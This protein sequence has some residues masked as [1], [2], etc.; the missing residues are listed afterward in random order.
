M[1]IK[2]SV[3]IP[4]RNRASLL[5]AT[6]ESI[7][8]QTYDQ[9]LFEVIVCDN[10]S[11]D[12]IAEIAHYFTDKFQHFRY[13]K[14]LE[15][16]LH[17]GRNK[18]FQEAKGEIL[19]YIDDD[20]E[21]FP[22]WLETIND[23]FKEKDVVLVGGKNLPKWEIAPP[24]WA[25]EMWKPNND[26]DRMTGSFSIIDL[27]NQIKEINPYY[28]F[29]CNFSIRKNIIAETQG[30]HPDGMPQEII[31]YRGD[32]ESYVSGYIK[33]RGYKTIYHPQASVYH[34]VTKERLTIEY[35]WKRGFNQGV[36]DS[37]T[38]IRNPKIPSHK[39]VINLKL[40]LKGVL[41]SMFKFFKNKPPETII[42]V[43]IYY[44]AMDEGHKE[45][46]CFHQQKVEE[47]PELKAW[48]M[49]DNYLLWNQNIFY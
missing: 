40:I 8:H 41:R 12:N 11:T 32:G 46:F 23:V 5:L 28:V 34:L 31:E 22:E 17:I 20:I 37:F 36:S 1:M 2:L 39:K 13:I 3:I 45:G 27:G 18:G 44:K 19:V 6:L 49:K 47:S 43:S 7:L 30:F 15:P 14:T 24:D 16:G 29:G 35:L 48:V 25:L 38:S 4:T 33:Q 10:N 42:E 21:A 26:G 9:K